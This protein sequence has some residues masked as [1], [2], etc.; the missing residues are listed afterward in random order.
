MS[1]W[2]AE[3]GGGGLTLEAQVLKVLLRFVDAAKEDLMALIQN[4]HTIKQ[5]PLLV[6]VV[7]VNGE[8]TSYAV[9]GA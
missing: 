7:C 4:R 1:A 3:C 5:L 6:V 8:L 9:C 2:D